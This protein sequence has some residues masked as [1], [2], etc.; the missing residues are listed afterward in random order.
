[1]IEPSSSQVGSPQSSC[2]DQ[3]CEASANAPSEGSSVPLASV[4]SQSVPPCSTRTNPKLQTLEA[5][6][7]TFF[8]FKF[9]VWKGNTVK[10][11]C[12]SF[13]PS[14]D[15]FM[16]S[17]I[18]TYFSLSRGC[19]LR[20]GTEFLHHRSCSHTARRKGNWRVRIKER[21]LNLVRFLCGLFI[22]ISK[23]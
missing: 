23:L 19:K 5:A 15:A 13:Q 14:A 9:N 18:A 7:S 1:M 20:T 10:C 17:Y 8:F 2:C 21:S 6:C 4:A 11:A 16:L 3:R 22:F 12:K